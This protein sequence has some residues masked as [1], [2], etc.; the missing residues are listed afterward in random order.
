M[1]NKM[2]QKK[3][4]LCLTKAKIKNRKENNV[5]YDAEQ[6]CIGFTQGDFQG[7]LHFSGVLFNR[8][9]NRIKTE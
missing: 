8:Y 7:C 6:N 2:P 5:L 3:T 9:N 1:L 4:R